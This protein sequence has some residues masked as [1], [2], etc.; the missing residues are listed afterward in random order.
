MTGATSTTLL[1]GAATLVDDGAR[2]AVNPTGTPALATAG[3]GDVLSG[4]VATLLAQGLGPYD[5]ARVGAYWHGLAGAFAERE[6]LRGV[7]AGDVAE[8]LGPSLAALPRRSA[9]LVRLC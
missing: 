9:R 5:A 3:T 1:K 4:V 2:L 8:A 7:V 6:R